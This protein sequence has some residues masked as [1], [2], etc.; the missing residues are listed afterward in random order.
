MKQGTSRS[1]AAR[2]L[3]KLGK[4]PVKRLRPASSFASPAHFSSRPKCGRSF[5]PTANGSLVL[6]PIAAKPRPLFFAVAQRLI[7]PRQ[8]EPGQL[9]VAAQL[10]RFKPRPHR[11]LLFLRI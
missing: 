9:Q 10:V 7:V 4:L 1:H 2:P 6:I 11:L 5:W 8:V 3:V